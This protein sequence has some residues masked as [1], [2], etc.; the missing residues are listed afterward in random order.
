V[1]TQPTL[2]GRATATRAAC[3][4]LCGI[5][6]VS[7]PPLF[8]WKKG[9]G[10]L[11]CCCRCWAPP[12]AGRKL[13]RAQGPPPS[14]PPNISQKKR[15]PSPLPR[16]QQGTRFCVQPHQPPG[17]L[18]PGGGRRLGGG[19][20][21]AGGKHGRRPGR[22]AGGAGAAATARCTAGAGRGAAELVADEQHDAGPGGA[23]TMPPA[24]AAAGYT[25]LPR[26]CD[27]VL[28]LPPPRLP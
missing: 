6:H 16:L 20:C 14:P 23:E 24:P 10:R 2:G 3:C 11:R 25:P 19:L 28:S 22:S 17:A 1:Q 7:F 18:R 26:R 27:D 9:M 15:M 12:K 21:W 8:I 5:P 13:C 4:E